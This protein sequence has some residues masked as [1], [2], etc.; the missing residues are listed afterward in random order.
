MAESKKQ[1]V[2]EHILRVRGESD[3]LDRLDSHLRT[4]IGSAGKAGK[5]L[6]EAA[7]S[8]DSLNKASKNDAI[9]RLDRDLKRLSYRSKN[10]VGNIK[11]ITR[12]I[13][14]LVGAGLGLQNSIKTVEQYNDSI[15]KLSAQFNK[16]GESITDV[17]KRVS[18]FS[19]EINLTRTAVIE[20]YSAYEKL[21]PYASLRSAEKI[22][23]NIKNIFGANEEAIKDMS[24]SLGKMVSKAPE[25][26]GAIENLTDV[27]KDRLR[28]YSEMLLI[29]GKISLTE[30]RRLQDYLNQNAQASGQDKE[31]LQ[32]AKD[33]KKTI[34]DMK[35]IWQEVAIVIGQAV[36][37]YLEKMAKWLKNNEAFVK[38]IASLLT[39]WIIPLSIASKTFGMIR[40]VGKMVGG[41][42]RLGGSL[43]GTKA[44]GGAGRAIAGSRTGRLIGG[45][46][47]AVKGA[48]G[49]GG[50]FA[51][52]GKLATAGGVVA[53]GGELAFGGIQSMATDKK[54]KAAAGMGKSASRVAG[55]A[56]TGAAV[57]S[58]IP[59]PV[60]GTAIGAI[61]GGLVSFIANFKNISKDFMTLFRDNPFIRGL[62]EFG[63]D[64]AAKTKEVYNLFIKGWKKIFGALGKAIDWVG[65]IAASIKNKVKSIFKG[66]SGFIDKIPVIGNIKKG[67]EGGI[68][69]VGGFAKKGMKAVGGFMETAPMFAGFSI[70][71]V[72]G[73]YKGITGRGEEAIAEDKKR[74]KYIAETKKERQ[75]RDKLREERES[76]IYEGR[77]G[78]IRRRSLSAGVSADE[79]KREIESEVGIARKYKGAKEVKRVEDDLAEI[80]NAQRLLREF[81]VKSYES[82]VSLLKDQ[83]NLILEIGSGLESFTGIQNEAF[84]RF[85]EVLEREESVLRD[86]QDRRQK[87]VQSTKANVAEE[88][89]AYAKAQGRVATER[90]IN[91]A[92]EETLKTSVSI[93][94]ADKD[95]SEQKSKILKKTVNITSLLRANLDLLIKQA[96]LQ[97]KLSSGHTSL[98]DSMVEY[99]K[100][101]GDVDLDKI[102]ESI[103]EANYEIDQ[104]IIKLD[105]AKKE[106]GKL[107][108]TID[109][110]GKGI[111]LNTKQS[112]AFAKVRDNIIKKIVKQ[113]KTEEEAKEIFQE[114]LES[115]KIQIDIRKDILDFTSK[116]NK[117]EVE[118]VKNY[119]K[120]SDSLSGIVENRASEASLMSGIVSLQDNFVVG[121]GASVEARQKEAEA[122]RRQV[123]EVQK[124]IDL[125]KE[126]LK[127]AKA[128]GKDRDT[129]L[130]IQTAINKR[131]SDKVALLQKEASVLKEIR[132]GWVSAINAQ[133][134]GT[135]RIAKLQLT[136]KKNM[137]QALQYFNTIRSAASGAVARTGEG[138]LGF[139]SSERF[140]ATES[141]GLIVQ[142]AKQ[143]EVAYKTDVGGDQA[144]MNKRLMKARKE[145]AEL[146]KE[147]R[148]LTA[149]AKE[150]GGA[151]VAAKGAGPATSAVTAPT[152]GA[153]AG[154]VLKEKGKDR[155]EKSIPG[156]TKMPVPV[157][158]ETDNIKIEAEG[159]ASKSKSIILQLGP[160]NVSNINE[161]IPIIRREL[162]KKL[163][164]EQFPRL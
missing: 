157:H 89:K 75:A 113:G 79:A 64:F 50:R 55:G 43:M 39:K 95:I 10:L 141:G 37:P 147:T 45:A 57:G 63:K 82:Q 143:G 83:K 92:Q 27:N 108:R 31:R 72:K 90:E 148:A 161:I 91:E 128:Q 28:S 47:R 3:N 139:R 155:L 98:V 77:K 46:G 34:Q 132:D 149:K 24:G 94:K 61:V 65:N 145:S 51:R 114:Q 84:N 115:G 62:V 85:N 18:K 25:L 1:Q 8:T 53:L 118:Q 35:R 152:V 49:K 120:A 156:K 78:K 76:G 67:L 163:Q 162:N 110:V 2:N 160:F 130:N 81:S 146:A 97:G 107:W 52:A 58:A 19:S 74:E 105:A 134:I 4:L 44:A 154:G 142:R 73:I 60:L 70:K 117:K 126:A 133:T 151:A 15:L 158:G 17:E 56:L 71:D 150:R 116:I 38:S 103:K 119:L 99:A 21:F 22:F 87:L 7:K 14:G 30:Q 86:L 121:L 26:Q 93:K 33:Y 127:T 80:L 68:K 59:I 32:R 29:T 16:Y 66:V 111:E 129:L 144:A 136:S 131:Q 104:E 124:Q 137:R 54:T 40:G 153:G 100:T 88:V 112:E 122:I 123:D 36:M 13:A 41:I 135:G 11:G 6:N 159:R 96:E 140:R 125:D 106:A 109:L 101:T 5:T 138:S 20:L 164:S 23:K 42:G 48:L 102:K 9:K 69:A 12:G